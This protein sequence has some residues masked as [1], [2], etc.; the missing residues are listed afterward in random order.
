MTS[1]INLSSILTF[2]I[3]AKQNFARARKYT[4]AAVSL[5]LSP[6]CTSPHSASF[7][8]VIPKYADSIIERV[9]H[10]SRQIF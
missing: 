8:H 4:T 3:P 9:T 6:K 2:D 7:D 5:S 1:L 10:A